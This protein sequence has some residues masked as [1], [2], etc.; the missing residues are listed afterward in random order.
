MAVVFILPIAY[1][2]RGSYPEMIV[3]SDKYSTSLV[4]CYCVPDTQHKTSHLI[5]T[6]ALCES[7]C[8]PCLINGHTEA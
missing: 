6:R 4:K 2:K 1:T 7:C 3:S 8:N 5:L